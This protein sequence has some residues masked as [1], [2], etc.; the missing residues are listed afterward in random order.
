MEQQG[1]NDL[2]HIEQCFFVNAM[3]HDILA[4]ALSDL[5]EAEQDMPPHRLAEIVLSMVDRGWIEVR[6]YI[7]WTAPDGRDGYTPGDVVDRQQLPALL[8]DPATWD[9]TLYFPSW[10]GAPILTF[11]DAGRCSIVRQLHRPGSKSRMR[12]D[13]LSRVARERNFGPVRSVQSR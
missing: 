12:R 11:T 2:G 8:T 3:E 5:D 7:A 6:R 10:V 1:F 4:G 9:Y 13:P